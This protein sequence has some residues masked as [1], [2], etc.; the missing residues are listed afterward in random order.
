MENE[1]WR[2]YRKK[3]DVVAARQ[4][5][6]DMTVVTLDGPVIATAKDFIVMDNFG[7]QRPVKPEIFEA[8]YEIMNEA[9]SDENRHDI[10]FNLT[11]ET[12]PLLQKIKRFFCGGRYLYGMCGEMDYKTSDGM[13]HVEEIIIWEVY[14]SLLD[15]IKGISRKTKNLFSKSS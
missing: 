9:S 1:A 4:V 12:Y 2:T 13:L 5:D 6:Y 8:E 7:Y 10:E 14:P 15:K 11:K 3:Q